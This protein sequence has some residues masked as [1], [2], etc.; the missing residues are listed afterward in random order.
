MRLLLVLLIATPAWAADGNWTPNSDQIARLEKKLVL[1]PGARALADYSRL[2]WGTTE[3]GD[4]I[5]GGALVYGRQLGIHLMKQP[6][7]QSITDQGCN[8]IFVRFDL[9]KDKVTANCDGVG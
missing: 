5:I 7:R 9:A 3:R 1:P 4:Q 6:I 8:W 2:Y